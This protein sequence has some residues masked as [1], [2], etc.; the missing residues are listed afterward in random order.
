MGDDNTDENTCLG[1]TVSKVEFSTGRVPEDPAFAIAVSVAIGIAC[2]GIMFVFNLPGA[3]STGLHEEYGISSADISMLAAAY[4]LPSSV[5]AMLAAWALAAYGLVPV[6]FLCAACVHIGSLCFALAPIMS[7]RPLAIMMVAQAING[8]GDPLGLACSPAM[9]ARWFRHNHMGLSMGVTLM[10]T[11][12]AG[13][14]LPFTLLPV[15]HSTVGFSWAL[16]T[17]TIIQI[18]PLCCLII[19]YCLERKFADYLRTVDAADE[20]PERPSN[21]DQSGFVKNLRALPAN[22]WLQIIAVCVIPVTQYVSLSLLPIYLHFVHG[23]SE[24]EAGNSTSFVWWFCVTAPFWGMLSDSPRIGRLHMQLLGTLIALICF[25]LIA[26]GMSNRIILAILGSSFAILDQNSYVCV[27]AFVDRELT[28]FAYGVMGALF[29]VGMGLVTYIAGQVSVTHMPL[30]YSCSLFLGIL[31]TVKLLMH[32][33]PVD[34]AKKGL[35]PE[36]SVLTS[37]KKERPPSLQDQE[38]SNIVGVESDKIL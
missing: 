12:L 25:L 33:D 9:V 22:A 16:W 3:L 13:A 27:E 2:A 15:V 30:V 35:I 8:A 20:V 6:C 31:I 17:G 21:Q 7:S 19:Y 38:L 4:T 28:D 1:D 36:K 23:M 34:A 5:T 18:G 32:L 10:V 11:Q 24:I 29:N 37:P 14:M 26:T